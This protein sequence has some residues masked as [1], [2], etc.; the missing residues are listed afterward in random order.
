VANF[1]ENLPAAAYLDTVE[2]L[3]PALTELAEPTDTFILPYA[4]PPRP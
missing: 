1:H 3:R 4:W 2:K